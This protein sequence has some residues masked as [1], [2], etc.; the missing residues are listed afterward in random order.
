MDELAQLLGESPAINSVREK[1]RQ[2]LERQPAGRRLPAMLIQGETGTG[3]GLVARL[4]HR[5]GPRKGGPFVDINCPAIPETLLEAE[6]F[7]FE[8]GAFTD[9]RRAKPG[10]FQAAHGGTLFLDEVGLLPG[11]VQAKLLTAIDER[12]VRRL[13]STQVETVDACI[14][15]ATNV[16]LQA[17]LRERRFREDLYHRLAVITLDLP[18]LR[19]RDRDVLLLAERFLARV[20]V[21]Y[22]LPPKHLDA[23]AQARLLAYAWPGNIRELSN[24]IERAAL[25]AESSVIT[26]AM[27][28]PLQVESPLPAAP[29]TKVIA[30]TPEEAMRQHLLAVLEQCEGNIS[31]AAAR[32]GIARNTLYARLEKFGVRGP[33]PSQP[34]LGRPS[35][36]HTAS[37]PTPKAPHTHWEQRGITLLRAAVLEPGSVDAWSLTSRALDVVIDKVQTFGGRVEEL[38]PT[39]LLASF[40]IDPLDDAPRRAAHAALAIHKAAARAGERTSRAPGIKIG[41]HVAQLLVGRSESRVDIDADAK[42]GLR[43]LLD[44]LLQTIET[45]ETVASTAAVPFLERRFELVPID[46]GAGSADQPYRLTGQ[47]RRG[48]GLWGAMTPF[49]G[50]H[51]D[52]EGL[53]SRLA[54]A[55]RGHGQ[56]VAVV[57]EPGVGKSRLI[58]EFT[59]SSHVD[60]WLVLEAGAVPYGKATPYLPVI[61]LLKAYCGIGDRDDQRAIREKVTD[62]LLALDRA[63]EVALPAFLTLLDLPVDDRAWQALDPAGRRRRTLDALKRLLLRESQ[64]QPLA[65]VFE[66][67]HWIDSETQ[68]LLDGLVDSLA[69]AHLLLLVNY[70]PEYQHAWGGKTSF[71]QLRL[72]ALPAESAGELLDALLGDD[73]GLAPLKQLLVGHGNPFFLEETVRTLVETKALAGERG[74]YRLTQPIQAI[75]VAATVQAMLAARIDRLAPEDKHLL[76]VASV[77]GKDVPSALLQAIADLPDEALRGGLDHLQAAEFLYE[78]GLFPDFEYSFKHALTHEVTYSGLLHDDRRALHARIVEAIETLH[79]D[80][81][82]EHTERLAHHAVRGELREK[83]VHYLRQAGG[84][85]AARSAPLDAR[86]WFEQALGVLETLPESPSTLE[87]A[88]EI[89]LELRPVLNLLDEVRRAL[90]RLR[91]AEALAERLNDDRRRGRVCAFMTL[92]HTL[93]AELDEALVAGTRALEIAGRLGDL[94]LR[95][96]TTTYL[97][98][99]HYYRGDYERVVE[100]ATD[101]LAA[102]PVDWVYEHFGNSMPISIYGRCFLVPSLA[103]LGRFAEATQYE[104]EALR[105]AEPTHHA[106]TVGSTHFA[107]STLYLLKGDWAKARSLIEHGVAA[108]RMGNLLFTL[109]RAVAS[110]AW[111]LAQLG[112]ASEALTRLRESEP[113]LERQAARGSLGRLGDAYHSLGRAGLLLGRLDEARSLGDR[114]LKYSLSHPGFAAHALHLLGDIATHPDR[115]D[116]ESGE[117]YYRHALALAEPRGMRPLVA[118]C[119]LGLGKLYRRTGKRQEAQGHLSTATSMYRAMDMR[120]WLEQAEAEMRKV[121]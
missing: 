36:P 102:L 121:A 106:Q 54:A 40:G 100:L 77:I 33:R 82:G 115:F 37:T 9:A 59:R 60:G 23:E 10:L 117:A 17:A 19:D 50:R 65:L 11:S 58:W 15:S 64:V 87:Q 4:V 70:R 93:L 107:A 103:E 81:L 94:R 25:F 105:L 16:D 39:G 69:S 24:V 66:D 97:E 29:A 78:T 91:E 20:C 57:G 13:G 32:L 35:Q 118:H 71:S 67:L 30:V 28:D 108:F 88:F 114:A 90:E 45:D 111:I 99:P 74:R 96:L 85:A 55:G 110:S 72:D 63:F 18:A 31:H 1:L 116:A 6:L 5:M 95:L 92:T 98:M 53:L 2:L 112:E 3:K 89:R 86:G 22:D 43:A 41:L 56:F 44:Q 12:A 27:L 48:L 104:A 42:R 75:Q 52:I 21:D 62:K 46:D 101:N 61:D 120:F 68:A 76:Q 7:G 26:G 47:E 79:G 84:K 34:P 80:R 113:L 73:P 109:P 38:T 8:R 14:I 83:A 49:V 51:D 119:H